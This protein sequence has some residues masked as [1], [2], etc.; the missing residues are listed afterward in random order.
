[1][2]TQSHSKTQNMTQPSVIFSHCL[3]VFII[4]MMIMMI[5]VS[6]FSINITHTINLRDKELDKNNN[7]AAILKIID[8][9]RDNRFIFLGGLGRFFNITSTGSSGKKNDIINFQI[10]K[11]DIFLNNNSHI[12]NSKRSCVT[13]YKKEN[14]CNYYGQEL[15]QISNKHFIC[16]ANRYKWFCFYYNFLNQSI[17]NLIYEN[18]NILNNKNNHIFIFSKNR[19]I[20]FLATTG[21]GVLTISNVG[22]IK[23]VTDDRNRNYLFLYSFEREDKLYLLLNRLTY[24]HNLLAYTGIAMGINNNNK[25]TKK[26][27]ECSKK[28]F[29]NT[30]PNLYSLYNFPIILASKYSEL[31]NVLYVAFIDKYAFDVN[32]PTSIALC[33]FSFD[34]DN[35]INPI[36]NLLIIIPNANTISI[37]EMDIYYL[38]IHYNIYIGNKNKSIL[39]RYNISLQDNHKDNIH[40]SRDITV[41]L[42]FFVH[43][44]Y[45][46]VYGEAPSRLSTKKQK[47]LFFIQKGNNLIFFNLSES[48]LTTS[49]SLPPLP[50]EARFNNSSNNITTR[51]P[52]PVIRSIISSSSSSSSSSD[53]FLYWFL[54]LLEKGEKY[55]HFFFLAVIMIG[56]IFGIYSIN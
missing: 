29:H 46:L 41:T 34:E 5:H 42:P 26:Q 38:Y 56:L 43:K 33:L 22:N 4:M 47:W 53:Y 30:Y 39:E 9:H 51:R 14:D 16:V 17:D 11:Y 52:T 7:Y 2:M 32:I 36:G 13:L 35:N 21:A 1:M 6:S 54:V 49:I 48:N 45:T 37:I 31:K 18:T 55:T 15:I 40:V 24:L 8:N 3:L 25:V 44:L 50:P 27:L 28:I 19:N 10:E 20:L 23:R 12:I